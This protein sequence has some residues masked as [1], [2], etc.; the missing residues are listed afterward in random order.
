MTS[1]DQHPLYVHTLK[2]ECPEGRDFPQLQSSKVADAVIRQVQ[3]LQAP[4]HHVTGSGRVLTPRGKE[5]VDVVVVE[6][7]HVQLVQGQEA[8][9]RG[10][11]IVLQV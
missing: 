3:D 9:Q 7:E 2:K 5:G 1:R 4:E 10:E 11:R 8:V 6:A